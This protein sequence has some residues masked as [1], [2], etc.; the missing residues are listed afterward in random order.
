[1]RPIIITFLITVFCIFNLNAQSK[2]ELGVTSGPEWSYPISPS[3]QAA[4]DYKAH[5]GFNTALRLRHNFNQLF[6][7]VGGFEYARIYY[8]N[9][10]PNPNY[11]TYD[12]NIANQLRIPILFQMNLGKKKSQYFL[13]IG[14]CF[15]Y[16][17]EDLAKRYFDMGDMDGYVNSYPSELYNN[18]NIGWMFGSGYSYS[19]LP[20]FRLFTEMRLCGAFFTSPS[21]IKNEG[22]TVLVLSWNFG[23]SFRMKPPKKN[24]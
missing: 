2:F 20:F 17:F 23:I 15:L 19:P 5:A 10:Q 11:W 22:N 6:S 1:M 4:Y 8:N 24:F 12:E 9:P 7:L 16:S 13:N 14:P 3:G 21:Q 18:A